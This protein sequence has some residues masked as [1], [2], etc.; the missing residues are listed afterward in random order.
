MLPTGAVFPGQVTD[1]ELDDEQELPEL[2]ALGPSDP[3][4]N[5]TSRCLSCR[6]AA[7]T[8]LIVFTSKI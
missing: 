5:D 7:L 6:R 4:I 1:E 2:K 8:N 3:K